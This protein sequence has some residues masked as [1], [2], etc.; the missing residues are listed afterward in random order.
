MFSANYVLAWLKLFYIF[1]LCTIK[2]FVSI[3]YSNALVNYPV[4]FLYQTG[5]IIECSCWW[6]YITIITTRYTIIQHVLLVWY[7]TLAEI[8]TIFKSKNNNNRVQRVLEPKL[9][10]LPY[11]VLKFFLKFSQIVI[12][13]KTNLVAKSPQ[14]WWTP[15]IDPKQFL[16]KIRVYSAIPLPQYSYFKL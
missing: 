12:L 11:R 14:P 1:T 4:W 13:K 6:W 16:P 3:C 8:M 15:H 10:N 7:T 9:C 2:C 5:V